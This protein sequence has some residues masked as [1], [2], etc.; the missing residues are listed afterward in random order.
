MNFASDNISLIDLKYLA[1]AYVLNIPIVTDDEEMIEFAKEFEIKTYKTLEILKLMLDSK[2][3]TFDD[4][5]KTICYLIY[6]K[7]LPSNFKNEYMYLFREDPYKV[8]SNAFK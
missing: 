2:H 7:D 4:V 6:I 3:I 8:Y 5:H 1:H